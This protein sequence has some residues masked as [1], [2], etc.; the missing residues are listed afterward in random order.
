MISTKPISYAY[1]YPN[2]VLSS[3]DL[4][5]L[6]EYFN[7]QNLRTRSHLIGMGI[8]EGLEL[9]WEA[10]G[11]D[12]SE[13]L[14]IHGG[15]GVSSMGNLLVIERQGLKVY[16]ALQLE[17]EHF[18]NNPEDQELFD[19]WELRE[20]G[21]GT[22]ID[23]RFFEEPKVILL[24]WDQDKEKGRACFQDSNSKNRGRINIAI[25]V[26]AVSKDDY[27]THLAGNEK[28]NPF[29]GPFPSVCLRRFGFKKDQKVINLKEIKTVEN[30]VLNYAG[31]C[32]DAITTGINLAPEKN[33]LTVYENIGK[34][35]HLFFG[36]DKDVFA[37][38]RA[39]LADEDAKKGKGLLRQLMESQAA[40]GIQYF[41][42]F[43]KDLT[44]TY[45]EF[46]WIVVEAATDFPK[47]DSFPNHLALGKLFLENNEPKTNHDFRT[48]VISRSVGKAGENFLKAQFLFRKMIELTRS[49]VK[50]GNAHFINLDLP[51]L[52]PNYVSSSKKELRITGSKGKSHPLSQRAIPYYYKA[53]SVNEK[54]AI[55]R[56]YWNYEAFLR[57]R[58]EEIPAY[59]TVSDTPEDKPYLI[60][61]GRLFCDMD[62]YDFF[63]V[64]GH[65]FKDLKTAVEEI[66]KQRDELNLP[67][68]LHCLRLPCEL[69]E[70][71]QLCDLPAN[72]VTDL[73][74]QY[75][76]CRHDLLCTLHLLLC[77]IFK[78]CGNDS[79]EKILDNVVRD[80]KGKRAILKG[81]KDAK[82]KLKDL[83]MT[84]N[85]IS[86]FIKE[87]ANFSKWVA[88]AFKASFQDCITKP[89]KLLKKEYER[90]CNKLKAL[91][92]FHS[93]AA[94]HPGLEHGAGVVKGGTLILV[95]TEALKEP[96]K[97]PLAPKGSKQQA[98][99]EVQKEASWNDALL[100]K[101]TKEQ[102]MDLKDQT[103]RQVIADF[104]LPYRLDEDYDLMEVL[105]AIFPISPQ[106][107][108][109]KTSPTKKTLADRRE[110]VLRKSKTQD[111][112]SGILQSLEDAIGSKAM[113]DL[114]AAAIDSLAGPEEE[115][116]DTS[117]DRPKKKEVKSTKKEP[118]P[119]KQKGQAPKGGATKRRSSKVEPNLKEGPKEESEI[120][121]SKTKSEKEKPPA[122][123]TAAT[124][125]KKVDD[126]KLP[127]PKEAEKPD[128]LKQ[129][130]KEKT[131]PAK[132]TR[133][134]RKKQKDETTP[135][136]PKE[137][138]KPDE[139][140]QEDKE[141]TPP[142]KKTAATRKKQED[143]AAPSDPKEAEKPDE[144]K[145][146][147][148][149]KT[150]PAKK[151][152]ATRKKQEDETTLP[153][154]KEAEKPDELEG[155]KKSSQKES[156]QKVE[157]E[158]SSDETTP[159]DESEKMDQQKTD[160]LNIF[161]NRLSSRKQ[162]LEA[163]EAIPEIA[164]NKAFQAIKN[165]VSFEGTH[166]K[167]TPDSILHVMKLLIMSDLYKS[168]NRMEECQE[169]IQIAM[170]NFFDKIVASH[171]ASV[172]E[173]I[174]LIIQDVL[175]ILRSGN[176][177]LDAIRLGWN[178][179]ELKAAINTPIIDKLEG[180]LKN[181]TS[182]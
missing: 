71:E 42:D 22:P 32:K 124:R 39:H 1:F 16:E 6:V 126:T 11:G 62:A 49:M 33:L 65:L 110:L 119:K 45:E 125:K 99:I 58:Q 81:R 131:P 29:S 47:I 35:F 177:D 111:S 106:P 151:T 128:E 180:L 154:P 139:L 159:Q 14:V 138:E 54:D 100:I 48:K 143:K 160:S 146:E 133:A 90:R 96:E 79:F 13:T 88:Q 157:E 130:E 98:F 8:K 4:N 59:H 83:L 101:Q 104:Y 127:D 66:Q 43:L 18:S 92:T 85:T 169:L 107:E 3:D 23:Q 163:L 120:S 61:S 69:N 67:F 55:V 134:T 108:V 178:K 176:A 144:L 132:K 114:I 148:K 7:L 121:E 171:T 173:D 140:K 34:K 64:E 52:S 73:E 161:S 63:R 147:D 158:V 174:R 17:K 153:D 56:K 117:V 93:F 116:K 26:I 2:Q 112:I 20:S 137:A 162:Q 141:K 82:K 145:Q 113:Q 19:A 142:A 37:N 28:E 60:K 38:L 40:K 179:A 95:Y 89:F 152:R 118:E 103:Y 86:D 50:N 97:I 182:E 166:L 170:H 80:T 41:Y 175:T 155:E 84:A 129:E 156:D 78:I 44:L 165:L 15:I 68:Q 94:K 57:G 30:F 168:S 25:R 77:D 72:L 123:K 27:E 164:E 9:E 109:K 75:Q 31:L 115:K 74:I 91:F 105:E 87:E 70:K 24:F 102:K 149:K 36:Q 10:K 167:M 181:E 46:R 122:K 172:P 21:N 136:D 5:M 53:E 51:L 135:P 76:K 12:N 150:P